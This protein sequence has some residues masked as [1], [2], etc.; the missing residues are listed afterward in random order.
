MKSTLLGQIGNFSIVGALLVV[1]FFFGRF[2]DHKEKVALLN[3]AG[4]V[5]LGVPAIRQAWR[6]RKFRHAAKSSG[7]AGLEALDKAVFELQVRQ[8][9]EFSWLDIVLLLLGPALLAAGFA[10]DLHWI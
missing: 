10:L 9:I 1:A 6:N 3:L 2:E 5:S 7:V 8:F 4:A